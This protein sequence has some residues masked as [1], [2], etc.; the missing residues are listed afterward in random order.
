[1]RSKVEIGHGLQTTGIEGIKFEEIWDHTIVGF[2]E[3]KI[4]PVKTGFMFFIDD[5]YRIE[6][7][8]SKDYIQGLKKSQD[9]LEEMKKEIQELENEIREKFKDLGSFQ[10][11]L[12]LNVLLS[13]YGN[14]FL[15]KIGLN[16]IL[17]RN[18]FHYHSVESE[19]PSIAAL[20]EIKK[21]VDKHTC[22]H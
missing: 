22:N 13:L 16:S 11:E 17:E 19:M 20:K 5:G 2:D 9:R 21:I 7:E 14:G 15:Q 1:M 8:K 10:T 12:H 4:N 6:K 18:G 3:K